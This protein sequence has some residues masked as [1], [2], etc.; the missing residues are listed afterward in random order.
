MERRKKEEEKGGSKTMYV[1]NSSRYH[2]KE[3]EAVPG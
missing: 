3:K 2:R 1:G